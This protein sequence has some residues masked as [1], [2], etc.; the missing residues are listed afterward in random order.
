MTEEQQFE[1]INSLAAELAR[2]AHKAP[3]PSEEDSCFNIACIV[4]GLSELCRNN[5]Q[6]LA[7]LVHC[8]V[9]RS[10]CSVPANPQAVH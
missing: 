7:K 10:G 5:T 8:L 3:V 2:L 1:A 4:R 6:A 9:E